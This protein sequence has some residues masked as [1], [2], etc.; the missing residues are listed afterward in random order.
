MDDLINDNL[1]ERE[2]TLHEHYLSKHNKVRGRF[3]YKQNKNLAEY[4]QIYLRQRL[5]G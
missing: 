5:Y 4:L 2:I 1:S 3:K